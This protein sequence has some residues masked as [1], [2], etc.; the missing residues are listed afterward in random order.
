MQKKRLYFS[1][2]IAVI[3]L[4]LFCGSASASLLDGKTV[5]YQYF[6]PNSSSPYADAGNGDYVVGSGIEITNIA[7]GSYFGYN[8]YGTIDISDTNIYVHFNVTDGWMAEPFNGFRISD[9]LGLIPDFTSVTINAAT[10][11][12]GFGASRISFDAD[13]IWINWQGLTFV[14]DT[15]VSLDINSTSVP[16]PATLLLLGFGLIGIAAVRRLK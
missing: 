11:M 13:N 1:Y 12:S 14:Y 10:N 3:L 5:N 7:N 16:E 2:V 4:A 6:F 15:V 9:A 8:R